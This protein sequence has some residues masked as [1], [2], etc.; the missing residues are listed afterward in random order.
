MVCLVDIDSNFWR[1]W[2]IIVSSVELFLLLMSMLSF[3]TIGITDTLTFHS[4]EHQFRRQL[5][6]ISTSVL[7]IDLFIQMIS[8]HAID[9]IHK[10]KYIKDSLKVYF[11]TNFIGDLFS[12]IP[13]ILLLSEQNQ[14][15]YILEPMS[16]LL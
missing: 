5:F 8:Q 1:S 11:K 12:R 7:I 6:Y 9:E 14:T 3:L 10:T 4:D 15:T 13:F 2:I 16:L